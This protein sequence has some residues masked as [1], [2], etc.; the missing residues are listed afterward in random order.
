VEASDDAV[1]PW[2][3]LDALFIG[4]GGEMRGWGRQDGGGLWVASMDS[5]TGGNEA[6]SEWA[7]EHVGDT[8]IVKR[9]QKT[10]TKKGKGQE[11]N[12]SYSACK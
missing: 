1:N 6:L 3:A 5:V 12:D 7:D 10:I 9:K 8:H 2:G 11:T 4:R